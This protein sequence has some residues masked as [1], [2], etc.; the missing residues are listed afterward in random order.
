[1]TGLVY[2][3]AKHF[4][5]VYTST[6]TKYTCRK[7]LCTVSTLSSFADACRPEF[8]SAIPL[9]YFFIFFYVIYGLSSQH[10][11]PLH[12]ILYAYMP[13][14]GIGKGEYWGLGD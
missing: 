6:A 9:L 7:V 1:M 10:I 12:W 5:P 3:S 14:T 11:H 13:S 2:W 4:R 8:R